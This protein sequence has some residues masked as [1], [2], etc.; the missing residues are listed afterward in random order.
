MF[1]Y[2]TNIYIVWEGSSL[3][4]GEGT[5]EDNFVT[6]IYPM[7]EVVNEPLPGLKEGWK[8]HPYG[9]RKSVPV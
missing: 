3:L 8:I 2:D 1:V 5:T 9:I 4:N 7:V 6:I